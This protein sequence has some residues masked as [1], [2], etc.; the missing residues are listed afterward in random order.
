MSLKCRM[1]LEPNKFG[2]SLLMWM[3]WA[4][5]WWEFGMIFP[6]IQVLI[7]KIHGI[8]QF[9]IKDVVLCKTL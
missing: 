7:L 2:A 6:P 1:A 9:L 3:D 4:H 5:N 8:L